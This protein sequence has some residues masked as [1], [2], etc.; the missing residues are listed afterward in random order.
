MSSLLSDLLNNFSVVNGNYWF[1]YR[2]A[3]TFGIGIGTRSKG[4]KIAEISISAEI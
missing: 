3:L 4:T 1:W 2:Y